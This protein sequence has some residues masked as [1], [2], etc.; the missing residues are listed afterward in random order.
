MSPQLVDLIVSGPE[1]VAGVAQ[2][3]LETTTAVVE[4]NE[5]GIGACEVGFGMLEF[6][7]HVANHRDRQRRGRPSFGVSGRTTGLD[8]GGEAEVRRERNIG[9]KIMA[10]RGEEREGHGL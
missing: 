4:T 10:E 3:T 8:V 5:L 2:R 1:L 6:T 9:G 7:P